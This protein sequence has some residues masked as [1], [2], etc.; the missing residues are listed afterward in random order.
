M[1]PSLLVLSDTRKEI[2]AIYLFKYYIATP[3]NVFL[4]RFSRSLCKL[5]AVKEQL[6]FVNFWK[7]VLFYILL[8][9]V[10]NYDD[11]I[12]S[13]LIVKFCIAELEKQ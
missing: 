7:N 11:K 2:S 12:N 3:N 13:S 5:N 9:L 1:S 6:H 4:A 8:I 10:Y